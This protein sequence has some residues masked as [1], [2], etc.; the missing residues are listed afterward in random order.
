MWKMNKE[1]KWFRPELEKKNLRKSEDLRIIK[2][3]KSDNENSRVPK[4]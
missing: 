4:L 3:K 1:K 2:T